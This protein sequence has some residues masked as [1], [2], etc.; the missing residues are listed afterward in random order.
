M[1]QHG[2]RHELRSG[3]EGGFE[4]GIGGAML[5]IYPLLL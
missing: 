2:V 3:M 5:G 1:S 4:I